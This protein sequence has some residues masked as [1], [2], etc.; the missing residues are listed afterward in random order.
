[1]NKNIAAYFVI[2]LEE[3]TSNLDEPLLNL[4]LD[5]ADQAEILLSN[6]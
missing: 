5:I 1:M 6:P 4:K 2:I 3:M